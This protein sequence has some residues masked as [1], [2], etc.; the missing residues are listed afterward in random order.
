MPVKAVFSPVDAF[1]PLKTINYKAKEKSRLKTQKSKIRKTDNKK[2]HP[3]GQ[4]ETLIH[5]EL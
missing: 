2:P 1:S 3:H 5:Y 4:G